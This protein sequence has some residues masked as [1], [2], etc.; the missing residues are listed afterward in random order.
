[1]GRVHMEQI[2]QGALYYTEGDLAQEEELE[3]KDFIING[4]WDELKLRSILS[5]DMAEH[6]I[7]NIRLKT[8]EVD[9]DKA[10]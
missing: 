1:M 8:S 9:I 7:L 6:I 3:V 10:W 4:V 2:L 5:E